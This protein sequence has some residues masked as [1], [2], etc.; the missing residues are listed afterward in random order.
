MP[1]PCRGFGIAFSDRIQHGRGITHEIWRASPN[2]SNSYLRSNCWLHPI[3]HGRLS[4]LSSQ[5]RDRG[6]P[7]PAVVPAL[8]SPISKGRRAPL[9]CA[10][11]GIGPSRAPRNLR[12]E[13]KEMD[14]S[15]SPKSVL[16]RLGIFLGDIPPTLS[17]IGK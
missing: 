16:R 7:A 2:S 10:P 17:C 11:F 12:L 6:C 13:Y 14:L 1:R 9:R 3:E 15:K 8:R 4:N 5:I